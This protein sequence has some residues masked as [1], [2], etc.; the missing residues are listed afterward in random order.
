MNAEKSTLNYMQINDSH[1]NARTNEVIVRHIDLD[2]SVNF[3]LKSLK[4]IAKLEIENLSGADTLYLDT[5][6]L[7][8]EKVFSDSSEN[9]AFRLGADQPFT[10][11][12]LAI[13]ISPD[14]RSVTIH[15]HTQPNVAAL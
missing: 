11:R 9:N 14:T 1:S 7:V 10:G 4:G 2:I 15:Y 5:R 13:S 12:S 6:D 3:G 8:I